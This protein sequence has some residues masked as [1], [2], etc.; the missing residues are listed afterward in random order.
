MR[1]CEADKGDRDKGECS[2][3]LPAF[4]PSLRPYA[5]RGLFYEEGK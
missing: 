5:A 3:L 1:S 4:L 2:F